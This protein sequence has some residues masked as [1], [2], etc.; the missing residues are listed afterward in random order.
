LLGFIFGSRT[1]GLGEWSEIE[2][3]KDY[4]QEEEEEEEEG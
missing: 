2:Q 3:T 4:M 1:K